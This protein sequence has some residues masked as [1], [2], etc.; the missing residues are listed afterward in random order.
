MDQSSCLRKQV[1]AVAVAFT[2]GHPRQLLNRDREGRAC[3]S[4]D[5]S[6]VAGVAL[7]LDVSD[8]AQSTMSMVGVV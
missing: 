7:E 5:L 2:L 6:A 8:A 4:F 3:R 1:F